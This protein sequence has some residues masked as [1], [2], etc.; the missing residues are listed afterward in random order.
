MGR[1]IATIKYGSA[2]TRLF[3]LAVFLLVTGGLALAIYGG[4]SYELWALAVGALSIIVGLMMVFLANFVSEDVDEEDEDEDDDRPRRKPAKSGT[5]RRSATDDGYDYDDEDDDD[6]AEER[7]TRIRKR[8]EEVGG[9]S[10]IVSIEYDEEEEYDAA[11]EGD[12]AGREY[13]P[14]NNGIDDEDEEESAGWFARLFGGRKSKKHKKHKSGSGKT[15]GGRDDN[16]IDHIEDA[17]GK[18]TKVSK[19]QIEREKRA[20]RELRDENEQMANYTPVVYRQLLH[21]YKVKKDF[22][23]IMIDESRKFDTARTPA[24]CWMKKKIVY[25]LLMEGNERV[26]SMPLDKFLYVTYKSEVKEEN[27]DAYNR[28]RNDMGVYEQFEDVMPTFNS[29]TNRMG[30]T[31]YTKNQYVLGGTVAVT[32]R[33]MRVL[34][35][36]YRFNMHIYDSLNIEGEHSIYFKRAFE[37]R[38]LWIDQ[39]IGQQEYQN[40]IGAILQQMVDDPSMSRYDCLDA[41]EQM[42]HNR[43]ITDEYADYYMQQRQR[44]DKGRR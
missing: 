5:R 36:K 35:A 29:F 3:L 18:K 41:L 27:L 42:V 17:G 15:S 39:V 24:L 40:V 1:L 14:F 26:E 9:D 21:R 43:L 23:P 44:R 11:G 8:R 4:M 20:S 25:F 37:A 31:N 12:E 32:P 33:S 22:I 10:K 30:I 19:E 28:I 2:K 16:G 34:R 6:D 13:D 38:L 7:H